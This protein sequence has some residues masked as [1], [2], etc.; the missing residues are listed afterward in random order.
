MRERARSK[1]RRATARPSPALSVIKTPL[2]DG[3]AERPNDPVY[4][5]A[6]F[7]NANSDTAPALWMQ[8]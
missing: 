5:D 6:Y 7:I 8:T 3:D 4:A 1:L 2:R